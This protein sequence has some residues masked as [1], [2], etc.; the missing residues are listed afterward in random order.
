MTYLQAYIIKYFISKTI[1]FAEDKKKNINTNKYF[2]KIVVVNDLLIIKL[3]TI[4]L[5][6]MLRL[7]L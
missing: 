7:I 4:C 2:K 6:T 1:I 3:H 5:L